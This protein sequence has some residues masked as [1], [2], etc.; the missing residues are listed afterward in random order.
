MFKGYLCLRVPCIQ[1]VLA[2]VV[3]GTSIYGVLDT[4]ALRVVM[5]SLLGMLFNCSWLITQYNKLGCGEG[6]DSCPYCKQQD[7]QEAQHIKQQA[8]T[9]VSSH[10]HMH[11]ISIQLHSYSL[12]LTLFYFCKLFP[13]TYANYLILCS[14][15]LSIISGNYCAP[16]S[17]CI[18]SLLVILKHEALFLISF[19]SC[20]HQ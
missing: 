12:S 18:K 13:G 10:S 11:M 14:P 16:F 15:L 2:V 9:S 20:S 5:P 19:H 8:H 17:S 7:L 6:N 4:Y 3:I 1:E